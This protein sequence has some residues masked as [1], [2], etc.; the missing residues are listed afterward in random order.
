MSIPETL[1][2]SLELPCGVIIK[3]RLCKSAMSEG[4]S[5]VDNAPT[6]RH[7]RLYGRW[8]DGGVGLCITGNVMIDKSA[9]GEPR[10]VVIEDERNLDELSEWAAA[11][12][13]GDTHIW[14]QLNHPGKQS[15]NTLSPEPVAPSAIGFPPP[16]NKFFNPP[17]AL[18]ETEIENLI[19][20]FARTAGIVKKAGF[21]GVQIHAAHGY[22]V[23]QFFS[24]VH[25]RRIDEWGGSIENRMR[26]AREIYRAIRNEVGKD[27]P[28]GIK[29]NSADFM[30]GGFSAEESAL[31]V[32]TLAEDGMDL[33]E[34]SGGTYEKPVMTGR[35][36]SD[37]RINAEAYFIEQA[38]RVRDLISTPILVTGGFRT[39]QGMAAAV[40]ENLVDMVGIARPMAVDPELP[41]K[42]LSGEQYT[43]SVR[44][45]TTG[46]KLIDKM[47][48]L[49]VTWYEQQLGYIARGKAVR[50]NQGVWFSLIKTL[51]ENGFQVFQK[52]RA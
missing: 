1:A 39:G 41:L 10:N 16:L 48:L 24:P 23:S 35:T 33:I 52:R 26:F 7:T 11:G 38:G 32:K 4:L 29:I 34:L 47:A 51:V 42:I 8:A 43:S 6:P 25:N 13:A 50:P 44:P 5:S 20:R 19:E 14:P 31:V 22:L 12:R 36:A 3:N 40:F 30:K 27:F 18:E 46:I 17:R 37:R 9:L 45:L 49:E 2:R 28:V 15:P 21:T